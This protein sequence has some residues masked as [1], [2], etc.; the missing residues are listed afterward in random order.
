MRKLCTLALLAAL[1]VFAAGGAA[2]AMP[3]LGGP[4]GIVSVPNALVAPQGQLQAALSF[5][6][7]EM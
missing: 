4:T 7:Q 2:Q 6:S 3:S 1:A 5:Q